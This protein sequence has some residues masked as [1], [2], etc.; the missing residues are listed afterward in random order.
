M[1]YL[2]KYPQAAFPYAQLLAENRRRGR[3]A[4]EFE[5][6]DTGVFDDDRY[7]DVFVEYAKG[8]PEDIIIQISII[9]QGPEAK[10]LHLL[11]T[12]W[13]RN[14]WSWAANEEKPFLNVLKSDADFSIIEA[15][16]PTA[17][18]NLEK[19]R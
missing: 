10:T 4:A 12:L 14:T 9:N 16:H 2:Y 3:E 13:F 19:P 6:L 1:K 8:S 15:S 17:S 7:F 5:L 18:K 11:P